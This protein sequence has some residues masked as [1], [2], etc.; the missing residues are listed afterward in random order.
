MDCGTPFYNN[1]CTVN[2]IIPDFNDLGV[3]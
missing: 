3:P 1:G 2:N